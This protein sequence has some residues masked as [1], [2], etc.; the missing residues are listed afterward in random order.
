M[1]LAIALQVSAVELPFMN[2]LLDTANLNLRDWILVF[3]TTSS[4]VVIIEMFK[5]GQAV[6]NTIRGKLRDDVN[7]EAL[8][9]GKDR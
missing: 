6:I 5:Y 2:D 4:I 7:E 3:I 8:S 1:L 9:K